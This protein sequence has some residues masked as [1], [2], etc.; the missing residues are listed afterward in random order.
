[1]NEKH[2][3]VNGKEALLQWCKQIDGLNVENF[4]Y[5]SFLLIPLF[6]IGSYSL[7]QVFN[8]VN[9]TAL[10]LEEYA[11]FSLPPHLESL[12]FKICNFI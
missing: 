4:G 9:S 7:K 6:R 3:S 12:I 2:T 8:L 5:V 1:M 10:F 11:A